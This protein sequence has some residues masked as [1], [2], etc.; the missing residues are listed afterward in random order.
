MREEKWRYVTIGAISLGSAIITSLPV[1]VM[2][3]YAAQA[4]AQAQTLVFASLPIPSYIH[5]VLFAVLLFIPTFFFPCSDASSY[6]Y[7]KSSAKKDE[8]E[9]EP[10]KEEEFKEIEEAVRERDEEERKAKLAQAAQ[11]DSSTE[12]EENSKSEPEE[13]SS[14]QPESDK[15]GEK[16]SSE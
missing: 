16:A 2:E 11:E 5:G 13:K 4:S 6:S 7:T 1:V 9:P 3:R 14:S 12:S 15:T 10:K 8:P